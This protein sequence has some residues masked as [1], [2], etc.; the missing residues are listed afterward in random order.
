MEFPLDIVFV[1]A[2]AMTD[3]P[4]KGPS[5]FDPRAAS[6]HTRTGYYAWLSMED[7]NHL[8]SGVSVSG[9]GIT[10]TVGLVHS[11]LSERWEWDT[12]IALPNLG[13][14]PPFSTQTYTFEIDCDGGPVWMDKD[15]TG[16]VEEFAS[17][18]SP[19]GDILGDPSVFS[20]TGISGSPVFYQVELKD[21]NGELIWNTFDN[22]SPYTF[23]V[24]S[25]P[26][27]DAD[28]TYLWWVLAGVVTGDQTNFSMEG[29][30]FNI[31]RLPPGTKGDIN[32]DLVVNVLDAMLCFRMALEESVTIGLTTYTFPYPGE[33][34]S[35]ADMN[36]DGVVDMIDVILLLQAA[37]A[38]PR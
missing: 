35:L 21:G 18:L 23:V 24:Y 37:I 2:G 20:W 19:S 32:Q 36:N 11:A 31:V 5:Y 22:P 28:V 30:E 38:P 3:M 4:I 15:I 6:V 16:Y 29:T 14:T 7:P 8:S 25:G 13:D 34:V 26:A 33:L 17:D 9:P 12:T 27:L 1:W 10:G